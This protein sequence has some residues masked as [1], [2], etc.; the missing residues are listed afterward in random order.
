MSCP[1]I[2]LLWS[3]QFCILPSFKLWNFV[4]DIKILL[5]IFL[6]TCT[7]LFVP[8]AALQSWCSLSLEAFGQALCHEWISFCPPVWHVWSNVLF[9]KKWLIILIEMTNKMQLYWTVYYS[10]VPWPLNMFRAILSLIIR[11]FQTVVTASGF[12]HI[13]HCR[14]LSWQRPA[15]TNMSKTG[16]CNYSLEAHDDVR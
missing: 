1:A 6:I 15:T 13:C 5:S 3:L 7:F 9:A 11:S 8:T 2:L 4:M 12:T 16:S 14:P 10:I